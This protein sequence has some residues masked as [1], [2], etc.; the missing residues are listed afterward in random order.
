MGKTYSV[1]GKVRSYLEGLTPKA[2][3]MLLR[4]LETARDEGA[5]DEKMALILDAARIKADVPAEPKIRL[6]TFQREYFALL[7]PFLIDEHLPRRQSARIERSSLNLI[8]TWIIRDVAPEL[9]AEVGGK[10][11]AG[12][13]SDAEFVALIDQFR[14]DIKELI[15][16]KLDSASHNPDFRR[17][18]IMHLG[19]EHVIADIRDMVTYQTH[20][21]LIEPVIENFAD[22]IDRH[23]LIEQDQLADKVFE[24][25][26]NHP[27]L[28][29]W[30][31]A[32]ALHKVDNPNSLLAFSAKLAES[33]SAGDIEESPFAPFVEMVLSEADRNLVRTELA[34]QHGP[35]PDLP[36]DLLQTSLS[37]Y[38][39]LMRGLSLE[40]DLDHAANWR[41]QAATIRRDISA[42]VSRDIE[43]TPGLV[44]RTL[45]EPRVN[46]A[47]ALDIDQHEISDAKRALQIL[48]IVRKAAEYMAVNEMISQASQ[49][50]DQTLD[51]VCR[52]LISDLGRA[53]GKKKDAL[54][55][56]VNVGIDYVEIFYGEKDAE[57]MRRSR[58][59]AL[60]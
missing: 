21:H 31:A 40:I 9:A 50:V 54:L 29:V 16:E 30:V 22:G 19:G 8:W 34:C 53:R 24:F 51:I 47:G 33:E 45:R 20:R 15:E 14:N 13:V 43:A 25:A 49:T 26:D 7:D 1:Q 55:A 4:G 41:K 48:G 38:Y 12:T 5:L 57:L 37:D 10:V 46:S 60:N 39:D 18:L 11:T 27:D 36:S 23:R 42:I 58:Q 32:A 35:N 6:N 2:R 59:A 3:D 28:V 44:R 52:T 56:A 17:R